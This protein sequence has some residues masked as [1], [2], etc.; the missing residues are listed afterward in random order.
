MC[1][2]TTSMLTSGVTMSLRVVTLRRIREEARLSAP[3]YVCAQRLS[4]ELE[5]IGGID[6]CG[7][8]YIRRTPKQNKCAWATGAMLCKVSNPALTLVRPLTSIALCRTRKPTTR[9]SGELDMA[10]PSNTSCLMGLF[11]RRC[12]RSK[13]ISTNRSN[14]PEP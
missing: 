2:F 10:S 9:Q 13:I 6:T 12:T 8:V 7:R 3:D 1:R 11:D 14:L 4:G 5:L